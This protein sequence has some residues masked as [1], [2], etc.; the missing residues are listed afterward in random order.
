MITVRHFIVAGGTV[1]CAAG[2]GL[3]MQSG[4]P[5][6]P[7]PRV[8]PSSGASVVVAEPRQALATVPADRADPE[9]DNMDISGITLTSAAPAPPRSAPQPARL[10]DQP[11]TL[12]AADDPVSDM[13]QDMPASGFSCEV[14]MTARTEAAAM[15][16][17][18]IDS[19]CM[20]E[21]RFTLHHQ[22]MMVTGRTDENGS[23]RMTV[24]ALDDPAVFIVS[25]AEGAGAVATAAVTS[26][27]LYD[28]Y[29]LQ[30]RGDVGLH[31]HAREDGADYGTPGHVWAGQ[32]RGMAVAARGEGGFLTRLGDA[33]LP[34]P[35]NT[36]LPDPLRAEIFSF[37]SG[38]A[39][40]VSGVTISIEA[41]VGPNN[42]DRDIE[43][44]AMRVTGTEAPVVRDILL[45]MPGCEAEG[46]FLVLKN[47]FD[48]LKIARN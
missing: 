40:D 43:A 41:E 29:V 5:G 42:C 20:T 14:K 24:P 38:L 45:A 44:Q 27:D 11:V 8:Q 21:T 47:P 19:P 32:A 46:E 13:P 39:P 25:F 15:V 2:L 48:D 17:V 35:L 7:A 23:A 18:S 16:A 4:Q 28:R 36:G 30:W 34:A 10:P 22:G 31:L 9:G 12:A 33:D 1:A 3:L 6:P 26:L 37:P